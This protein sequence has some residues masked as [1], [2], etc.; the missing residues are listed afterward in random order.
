MWGALLFITTWIMKVLPNIHLLA[1]FIIV[2]TR[3]YR[4]GALIPI[5]IYVGLEGLW[6]GFHLWWYPYLYIWT[7]LWAAVM[8]LPRRLPERWEGLCYCGLGMLHGLLFGTMWAPAQALFFGLSWDGT[9]AWIL[10]GLPW[11]ALHGVSNAVTCTLCVPL[12]KLI[13][14]LEK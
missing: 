7:V 13:N 11:D 2:L 6:Q 1:L 12:I 5:Y 3:V 4:V 10:T 8:L 9:V 14:K